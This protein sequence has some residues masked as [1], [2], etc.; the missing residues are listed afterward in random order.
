LPALEFSRPSLPA[1]QTAPGKPASDKIMPQSDEIKQRIE[2]F[3]RWQILSEPDRHR[4]DYDP[5]QPLTLN[6]NNGESNRRKSPIEVQPYK[7][8]SIIFK[9]ILPKIA[10]P[11][12][13]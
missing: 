2:T 12:I 9:K 11:V 1:I 5:D 3:K 13:R 7:T 4:F 6:P 10:L 8:A